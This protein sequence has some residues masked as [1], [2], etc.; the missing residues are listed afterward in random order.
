MDRGSW[1]AIVHGVSKSQTQLKRLVYI[2][3]Y[4]YPVC[5]YMIYKYINV[6]QRII[7]NAEI[8]NNNNN[9]TSTVARKRVA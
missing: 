6:S 2:Y 1:W 3:I 9:F 5:I 7:L 8:F 4:V